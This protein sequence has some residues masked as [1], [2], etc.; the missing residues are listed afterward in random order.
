MDLN[1]DIN[2]EYN[3]SISL[4]KNNEWCFVTREDAVSTAIDV[5]SNLYTIT[6]LNSRVVSDRNKTIIFEAKVS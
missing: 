6:G 3:Y 1:L 2:Y 4:F 5:A